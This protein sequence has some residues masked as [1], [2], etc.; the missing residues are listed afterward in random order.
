MV[1]FFFI[2]YSHLNYVI[3]FEI[4]LVDSIG[5]GGSQLRPSDTGYGWGTLLGEPLLLFCTALFGLFA[6]S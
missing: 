3:E 6:A 4:S 1:F 5:S 2:L